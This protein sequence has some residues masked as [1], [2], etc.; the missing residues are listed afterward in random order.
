MELVR[1][2]QHG[3]QAPELSL[4]LARVGLGVFFACS[5]YNKL[6]NPGRHAAIVETFKRDHV[7]LIGFNQWWVPS[8]EFVGGLLLVLGLFTSFAAFVLSVIC[9]VACLCEARA[10]VDAYQPINR[11]DRVA[12]YLYLPEVIYLGTL[13]ALCFGGGGA[14]SL[15]HLF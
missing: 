7:P 12:D 1:F 9:G 14:F 15:D 6:F 11:L 3:L 13:L 4:A 10:R 2:A 8:W 5:G